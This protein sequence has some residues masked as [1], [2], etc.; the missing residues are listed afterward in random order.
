MRKRINRHTRDSI[1]QHV[2]AHVRAHVYAHGYTHVYTHVCIH[3]YLRTRLHTCL[4][5]CLCTCLYTRVRI[6]TPWVPDAS[7]YAQRCAHASMHTWPIQMRA[8]A[9]TN[10]WA[11]CMC[12]CTQVF[13]LR[14]SDSTE[15][16]FSTIMIQPRTKVQG[17][18]RGLPIG[19][20]RQHDACKLQVRVAGA[21]D[22]DKHAHAVVCMPMRHMAH[23]A[24]HSAHRCEPL[25]VRH[26][27]CWRCALTHRMIHG[28]ELMLLGCTE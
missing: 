19:V 28:A 2:C 24:H 6:C 21:L 5:T 14:T 16:L 23:C 20:C 26:P 9:I 22:H 3:T 4:C 13:P 27:T 8:H 11:L 10:V 18:G 12:T 1:D 17:K 15:A 7:R 25:K